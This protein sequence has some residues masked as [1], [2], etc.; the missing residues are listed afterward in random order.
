MPTP[1]HAVPAAAL[2]PSVL[3]TSAAASPFP[4]SADLVA[5]TFVGVSGAA[6]PLRIAPGSKL[7]Q[8][9]HRTHPAASLLGTTQT[10]DVPN[11]SGPP[12]AGSTRRYTY[13]EYNQEEFIK[14]LEQLVDP[15][16]W[17]GDCKKMRK[18]IVRI[19]IVHSFFLQASHVRQVKWHKSF[20]KHDQPVP[21]FLEEVA[22]FFAD[23]TANGAASHQ[24]LV[25]FLH[26]LRNRNRDPTLYHYYHSDGSSHVGHRIGN[27]A[28]LAALQVE[29]VP[30]AIT[31]AEGETRV[32]TPPLKPVVSQSRVPTHPPVA[33][34]SGLSTR[35][36]S[37]LPPDAVPKR[38]T[39]TTSR[40]QAQ[41]HN[42]TSG[43][44]KVRY[45]NISS[46]D[47]EDEE[48]E[49]E[50]EEDMDERP[51]K[52]EPDPDY[53]TR[54]GAK[55][56]R[57]R[58]PKAEPKASAL[59]QESDDDEGPTVIDR[60]AVAGEND[61]ACSYCADH[62]VP[63]EFVV[64]EWITQCKLCQSRRVGCSVS[65]A[66]VFA[67]KTSG[68][69]RFRQFQGNATVKKDPSAAKVPRATPAARNSNMKKSGLGIGSQPNICKYLPFLSSIY[70][71]NIFF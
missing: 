9:S 11:D 1:T 16:R 32:H 56:S 55:R 47:E 40:A 52:K 44:G 10:S 6:S 24:G 3:G 4:A 53:T 14:N 66:K 58:K 20:K 31:P 28:P 2:L 71:S 54:S 60:F 29:G 63:C 39:R 65:P 19:S 57:R 42:V 50:S 23:L 33:G 8:A 43:K 22:V 5:P 69:K 15:S 70:F 13:L 7:D 34:P 21:V 64:D 18:V 41:K 35:Q 45:V 48:D 26:N 46:G 17:A 30:V 49:L 61:P 36:P 51:I 67:L 27:E 38:S 37:H 12:D 59:V 25:R 68:R 62:Q